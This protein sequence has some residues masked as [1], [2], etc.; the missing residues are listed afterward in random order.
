MKQTGKWKWI[1]VGILS[2]LLIAVIVFLN[3]W[4]NAKKREEESVAALSSD[5]YRQLYAL[6]NTKL[7]EE[8]RI[9]K[10]RSFTSYYGHNADVSSAEIK[11]DGDKNGLVIA[12]VKKG[13]YE[14]QSKELQQQAQ[15]MLA[16]VPQLDYVEYTLQDA[17]YRKWQQ[18]GEAEGGMVFVAE[19]DKK[20]KE[21][22]KDGYTFQAFMNELR[23]VYASQSLHEAV[24]KMLQDKADAAF[25]DAECAVESHRIISAFAKNGKT[26]VSVL[27]TTG[28]Y[29][30]VNGNLIRLNEMDIEP[31][32]VLLVKNTEGNYEVEHADFANIGMETDAALR[33]MFIKQTAEKVLNNVNTFRE[34]LKNQEKQAANAYL[35]SIGRTCAVGTFADYPVI[36]LTSKGV[37]LETVDKI[38]AEPKLKSYPDWIGNQEVLEEGI[39]YVY[40]TAYQDTDQTILFQKTEYQSEE[41][42]GAYQVSAA[43]GDFVN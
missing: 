27:T 43:T 3:F 1:F 4:T 34:D 21:Y 25:G 23:P 15:V 10:I 42:K 24:G 17:T 32:I 8:D 40:K 22:V 11:K 28:G 12:L 29:R 36:H 2:V 9:G 30:F 7:K 38:L 20:M 41:I 5:M 13:N 39:R 16:L 35:K 33:A 31:A 6:K 14:L 18:Y 26:E 37:A 19:D